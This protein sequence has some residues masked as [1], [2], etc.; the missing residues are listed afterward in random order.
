MNRDAEEGV[1]AR[2]EGLVRNRKLF[3]DKFTV[4]LCP[5]VIVGKIRKELFRLLRR[6]ILGTNI[7]GCITF[8]LLK[9]NLQCI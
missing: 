7:A 9:S 1:S 3:G 8:S 2:A 6:E 4:G 5:R